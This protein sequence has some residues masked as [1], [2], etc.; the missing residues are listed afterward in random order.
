MGTGSTVSLC[1]SRL[2]G[3]MMSDWRVAPVAGRCS[4]GCGGIHRRPGQYLPEPDESQIAPLWLSVERQSL[5]L[6]TLNQEPSFKGR[7]AT[8]RFNE[9]DCDR[10]HRDYGTRS[11]AALIPYRRPM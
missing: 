6:R 5:G 9:L 8:R 7:K 1:Q 11:Y 4:G 10:P 3:R 2:F